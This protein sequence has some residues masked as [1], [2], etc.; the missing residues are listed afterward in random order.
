MITAASVA[1]ILTAVWA[2][3]GCT[4]KEDRSECPMIVSLRP[5]AA[6]MNTGKAVIW[7]CSGVSPTAHIECDSFDGTTVCRRSVDRAT[8]RI[9][10]WTNMTSKTAMDTEKM[11]LVSSFG[12][13]DS[14]YCSV[15]TIPDRPETFESETRFKRMYARLII[16]VTGYGPLDEPKKIIVKGGTMGYLADKS[17]IEGPTI[18]ESL[19]V[20][21]ISSEGAGRKHSPAASRFEVNIMKQN[22]PRGLGLDI[23]SSA[24]SSTSLPLGSMLAEAGADTS[25]GESFCT[26]YYIDIDLAKSSVTIRIMPWEPEEGFKIEF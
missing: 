24:G 22:D 2:L 17:V 18:V 7:F 10:A 1:V 4:V 3:S 9:Y 6:F 5:E 23:I 16:S 12:D 25:G 20:V 21:S 13:C 26:D 11:E 14:L 15:T 8:D 19:P